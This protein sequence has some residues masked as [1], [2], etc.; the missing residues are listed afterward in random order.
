MA[1]P[2]K[3]TAGILNIRLHPHPEGV[4]QDFIRDLFHL[5]KPVRL[6]GDRWGMISLLNPTERGGV[7]VTG[8][9]TTFTKIDLDQPWFD[10][11]N[12]SE[13]ADDVV[14]A[15]DLPENIFPNATSFNFV[16]DIQNH[17]LYIQTY[18]RGS[19]FS[20]RLA[21]KLFQIL[22]D[23][24]RITRRFGQASISIVQSRAGLDR[25]F[26]L[27]VL[28]RLTFVLQKPNADVFEEDFDENIEAYLQETRAKQMKIELVAEQ[29]QSIAPNDSLRRVGASALENG[30]VVGEGR[31]QDGAATRSTKEFPKE[32][33]GNF[34][35]DAEQENLAFRGLV[36]R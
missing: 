33:V 26:A 25:I 31:D 27:P 2:T 16:F 28:K 30:S 12:L 9:I 5:R 3:M 19:T 6:H 17:R 35:P 36:G 29:G 22:S 34:D 15:I 1:R 13:A 7:A 23:N 10:A 32:I 4:Y 20:I 18:S 8:L 24:L 21:D 11:V 14:A